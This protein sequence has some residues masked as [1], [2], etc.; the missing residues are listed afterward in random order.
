[1]LALVVA[2]LQAGAAPPP[3]A[4]QSAGLRHANGAV[5]PSITAVRIARAPVLDGRLDDDAWRSATPITELVQSDPEEGKPVSQTTEVRIV[6]DDEALY[7]GARLN[8]LE[9]RRIIARLG[10][11]DAF[12]ASDDF[13]VLIDSYH[14]HNTAFRFDVNA[15]GVRGDI[16]FGSDGGFA[17]NSWD[18]VWNAATSRDSLGWTVEERIPFSQLR[19]SGAHEQVWGIR[20]VRTIQRRNEFAIW[21]FIGK[22]E[23]GFVSRFGHL[24][25]IAGIRA[26]RRLEVLPYTVT[27]GTSSPASV[28]GS[29]LEGHSAYT[30]GAGVDV[31]YGLTS[32][33]TLD[34]TINP[35]FGQVESDPAFVNLTAFEQFLPERRPFFVE[36]ASIFSFGGGGQF[37]N[38]GGTPRVFYS[39]RIGRPPSGAYTTS[40]VPGRFSNLPT[41]TTLLGA[42]KLSGRT[43]GGWSVG[44]V[45]ALTPVERASFV[46]TAG[47]RS[48]QDAEPLTNYFVA[49]AK[50]DFHNGQSGVGVLTTAVNRDL[51]GSG[52][53]L[54]RSAAYLAGADFFHRWKGNTYSLNASVSAAY[55][56]GDTLAIQ[57]A[58][59]ASSR[60][61]ARPDAG[62]VDYDPTRTSLAGVSADVSFNKPGGSTNWAIGGSTTTPGYEVN[63]LGFQTRVD[64][65]SAAAFLGHRWTKPG[66]LFR[67]ASVSTFSGPSWNYD[68]DNIQNS[69]NLGGFAQLLNFWGFNVN[70]GIGLRAIDDRLTRGGPLAQKPQ[71][72]FL[73]AGFFTDN[74]KALQGS[75]FL[76]YNGDEAGGWSAG[77]FPFV[78]FRPSGAVELSVSPGYFAGKSRAQFVRR[79]TDATAAATYGARYV[80]A[81]LLQHS[82]DVTLRFNVTMSPTLSFQLYAQ[83]F[84][85]AGDYSGFKE[86]RTPRTFDFNVYGRDAGSTLVPGDPTV[87]GTAGPTQCY[88]VDPDGGGPAPAFAVTNPDFRTRSLRSNAVLRWE[89]RPGSTIYL[90]WTQS[91]GSFVPFDPSFEVGRDFRREMFL[92]RPENV[93]LVK[94]NYWLSL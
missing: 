79:R 10:R 51:Q 92:D 23:S 22:T 91:R 56:R 63:D 54:L 69:F 39:R 27:R 21:P 90:V 40:S 46:D 14:D 33:L 93:L 44:V 50:R 15:A 47:T 6:Y 72:Y 29:P 13:R 32:N 65:L 70:G 73:G 55:V 84:T 42:A 4:P 30:G 62:H 78:S 82:V 74:R 9:A 16:A 75:L 36:G 68:G 59:Q 80:F 61:Y 60:Y 31:K 17:D 11:R 77:V 37:I 8:D 66:K 12:T 45:Q 19:F 43:P 83:P 81:D 2:V 71:S 5:P 67:F 25:G 24:L 20:F 26:P 7:I 87:C 49:R 3:P 28:N 1:M 57:A 35:D 85:F 86:L 41:N 38:F 88:G 48:L 58:Q 94:V 53:N 18:P 52:F 64:R 89:Y 76:N 34:A